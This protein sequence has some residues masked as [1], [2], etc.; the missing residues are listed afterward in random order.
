MY[1]M[2]NLVSRPVTEVF[3]NVMYG[4]AIRWFKSRRCQQPLSDWLGMRESQWKR[5]VF[6]AEN[7]TPE[8]RR[9]SFIDLYI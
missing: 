9:Q 5:I 7:D 4:V 2:Q 8:K 1:L 3:I 6:D